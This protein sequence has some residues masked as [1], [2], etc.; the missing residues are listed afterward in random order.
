[1]HKNHLMISDLP[2]DEVFKGKFSF[3]LAP[4]QS[5][6]ANDEQGEWLEAVARD[7]RP[8]Y[9]LDYRYITA[10]A[11]FR[12]QFLFYCVGTRRQGSHAGP[13]LLRRSS[14]AALHSNRIHAQAQKN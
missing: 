13:S 14:W 8:Y 12:K 9:W 11:Y 1:M 7:G 2:T 10:L 4:W 6:A 3:G 5:A